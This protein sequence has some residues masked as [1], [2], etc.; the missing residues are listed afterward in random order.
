M[1]PFS[2]QFYPYCLSFKQ[3]GFSNYIINVGLFMPAF[4]L[5]GYTVKKFDEVVRHLHLVAQDQFTLVSEKVF[6]IPE[7]NFTKNIELF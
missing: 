2:S 6:G 4:F 1:V 5:R 3:S 7:E